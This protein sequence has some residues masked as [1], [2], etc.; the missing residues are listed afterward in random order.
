[1]REIKFRAWDI[2]K[3][4][5]LDW[6]IILNELVGNHT[7][8]FNDERFVFMQMW[9]PS[10]GLSLFTGDLVLAD[11]SPSGKKKRK[12][13]L[14]KISSKGGGMGVSV[15]YKGEWWAYS[16]MDFTSMEVIGNIYENPELLEEK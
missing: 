14:C 8:P 2:E 4:E 11:C 13:S 6:D 16:S 15:W 5:M 3:E 1:M 10:H 7:D 9:Q 12:S